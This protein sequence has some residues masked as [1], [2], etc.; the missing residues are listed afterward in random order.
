MV[1]WMIS[2]A[3]GVH[4]SSCSLV[5]I[6]NL[7]LLSFVCRIVWG[8]QMSAPFCFWRQ[9]Y[10]GTCTTPAVPSQTRGPH[11]SLGF[12]VVCDGSIT[13]WSQLLWIPLLWTKVSCKLRLTEIVSNWANYFGSRPPL[14]LQ[15]NSRGTTDCENGCFITFTG[16]SVFSCLY[17]L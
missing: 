2:T 12:S 16:K 6:R 1:E 11:C 3:K 7:K 5:L 13:S 9:W 14:W 10:F 17:F 4:V 15:S 8:E